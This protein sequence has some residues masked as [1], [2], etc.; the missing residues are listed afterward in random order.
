MR[1]RSLMF[2]G[3]LALTFAVGTCKGDNGGTGP[4]GPGGSAGSAGP[5]GP[6]GPSFIVGFARINTSAGA[7][8]VSTFGGAGTTGASVVRSAAGFYTV[9]FTGT[10]PSTTDA[11]K[12]VVLSTA[13]SNNF[14]VSNNAVL[15]ASPT[16]ISLNVFT[17]TSNALVEVDDSFFL[18]VLLGQ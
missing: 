6:A 5:A 18:E 13:E 15:S 14:Q 2:A 11:T 4:T 10:Y 12:L 16:S 7:S 9:T 3:L 8:S 17:W 1:N